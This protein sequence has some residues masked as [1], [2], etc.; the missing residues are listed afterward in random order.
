VNKAKNLHM[1]LD[2]TATPANPQVMVSPRSKQPHVSASDISE[3]SS[4]FTTFITYWIYLIALLLGLTLDVVAKITGRSRFFSKPNPKFKGFPPILNAIDSFYSRRLYFRYRDV[5][6][7]PLAGPPGAEFDVIERELEPKTLRLVLTDKQR[8]CVNLGS[9]NYLGISGDTW[10]ETCADQVYKALKDFGPSSGG[11]ALSEGGTTSMHQQLEKMVA[12]FVG[13][14][15]AVV[16]AQ[17][18]GT[19]A[20]TIP[21]LMGKGTLVVSDSLNHTSI[22]NGVRASGAAVRVFRH[23]DAEDLE[24][25][26]RQAIAEGQPKTFLPYKKILV[27]TEGIF[28]ME[29]EICRLPEVVAVCKRYKAFLYVDEAHSIGALGKSGRGVCEQTGVDPK[30][31][32]ILMGTFTKSFGAMGGYI[33]ASKQVCDYL[34]TSSGGMVRSSSMSPV[35]CAQIMASLHLIT[36]TEIGKKKLQAIKDNANYFREKLERMGCEVLGDRDSPVLPVMLYIPTKISMFSRMCFER[37]VAVV[38][39]GF[40][41]VPLNAARTRVCISAAHSKE[42]LDRA[43]KEIEEVVDILKLRYKRSVF[44]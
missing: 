26:L 5:W 9:Y 37:N 36:E 21:S 39:V 7:R 8:R 42:Q 28:S 4:L 44:G 2:A 22:V 30:D 40:P 19:N 6:N 11:S 34:R 3:P 17:G 32:D 24:Q 31:V 13:K 10:R 35:V 25:V 16:Y 15:D 18:Y 41:A 29:G 1:T 27:M 33:A 12:S 38:V 20:T 23:N 43:L 14:E